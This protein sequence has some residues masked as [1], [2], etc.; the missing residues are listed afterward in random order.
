MELHF[1]VAQCIVLYLVL[2]KFSAVN[3]RL[4]SFLL[5][6]VLRHCTIRLEAE[7]NLKD[8]VPNDNILIQNVLYK[9]IFELTINLHNSIDK[10]KLFKWQSH[11][12]WHILALCIYMNFA[13]PPKQY[14]SFNIL[15][16]K[17]VSEMLKHFVLNVTLYISVFISHFP[18]P[19]CL[20]LFSI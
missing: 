17:I 19:C 15:T 1:S 8:I 2:L 3:F 9:A 16:R 12:K 10:M 7:Q 18:S 4:S 6:S 14:S 13:K 20:D 5:K 11:T